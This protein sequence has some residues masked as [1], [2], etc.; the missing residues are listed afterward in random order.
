VFLVDF[1]KGDFYILPKLSI[2]LQEISCVRG[3]LGTSS[4]F[5]S[6]SPLKESKTESIF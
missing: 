3:D 4:I 5:A 6:D 1:V 2:M